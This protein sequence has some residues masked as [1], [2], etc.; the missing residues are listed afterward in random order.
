MSLEWRILINGEYIYNKQ[1]G[2]PDGQHCNEMY[3]E[4]YLSPAHHL[5]EC[6][7]NPWCPIHPLKFE[8][9]LDGTKPPTLFTPQQM[10]SIAKTIIKRATDASH[11]R[12]AAW[13]W[14]WA[15]EDEEGHRITL[16]VSY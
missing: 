14:T 1:K 10:V 15:N 8:L 16:D 2:V 6:N 9:A 12:A 7:I 11:V 4:R 3:V 13:L 5:A